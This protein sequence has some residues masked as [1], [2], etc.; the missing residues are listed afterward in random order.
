MKPPSRVHSSLFP[1]TSLSHH[2]PSPHSHLLSPATVTLPAALSPHGL[3]RNVQK[4]RKC[5][6]CLCV[7]KAQD[8]GQVHRK[9]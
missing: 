9:G 2:A 7:L 1:D 5:P 8:S 6:L 4:Q 3:P